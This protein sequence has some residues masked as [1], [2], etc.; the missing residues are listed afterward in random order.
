MLLNLIFLAIAIGSSLGLW[1]GLGSFSAWWLLLLIPGGYVGAVIF[2]FFG[3]FIVSL[4]MPKQEPKKTSSICR[5]FIW[6]SMD[7]LMCVMG[8]RVRLTG[9]ERL[10][11][12]PC[13]FVSNHRSDFDPMTLLAVFRGRRIVYISKKENFKIP[14]VGPFICNAGFLAI[15]RENGMRALRTLKSA[16]ERMKSEALDVGIYPEGTRSRTGKLLRFKSGAFYLAK[17]ADAPIV[18]LTTRGTERVSKRFL[19]A[20]ITVHLDVV[21]VIDRESVSVLSVEE[22]SAKARATV[23][24]KLSEFE[25]ADVKKMIEE[26]K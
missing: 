26:G 6:I 24:E 13:V 1:L 18:I 3:L 12:C 8:I 23:E 7:W 19:F 25:G 2:Y 15:D 4:F 5:F 22:L 20:P 16:A 10:P 21:D 14:I 11:S 9:T 17:E